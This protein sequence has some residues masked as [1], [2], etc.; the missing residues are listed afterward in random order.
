[1]Q[2]YDVEE[3]LSPDALPHSLISQGI[4]SKKKH[5]KGDDQNTPQSQSLEEG[6]QLLYLIVFYSYDIDKIIVLVI[7][8]SFNIEMVKIKKKA[9]PK[10]VQL[11]M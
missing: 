11:K 2:R 3:S 1:M 10:V 5:R 7:D 8:F 4:Q 6:Y 9:F